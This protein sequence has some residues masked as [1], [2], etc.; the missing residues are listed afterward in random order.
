MCLLRAILVAIAYY[1]DE[2]YKK[3]YKKPNDKRM[4]SHVK[5]IKSKLNLPEHG[6]GIQEI[7]QIEAFVEDYCITL[8]DGY[9]LSKFFYKGP[10][11]DKSFTYYIQIRITTS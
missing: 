11:K 1:N 3:S 7:V 6:C 5:T 4:A 10:K 9:S 8:I 2:P